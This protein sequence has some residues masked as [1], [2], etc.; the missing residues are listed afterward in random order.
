MNTL[1]NLTPCAAHLIAVHY[2]DPDYK[3]SVHEQEKLCDELWRRY[4]YHNR[5]REA[6]EHVLHAKCPE[7]YWDARALLAELDNLEPKQ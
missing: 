1:V 6:L 7:D 2:S 5:L 3:A 4:S